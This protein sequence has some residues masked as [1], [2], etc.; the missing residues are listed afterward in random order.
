M[1]AAVACCVFAVRN[2][3]LK[4]S[5]I[6]RWMWTTLSTLWR[7]SCSKSTPAKLVCH[8]H[9]RLLYWLICAVINHC[10][11]LTTESWV[12]L[13][14]LTRCQTCTCLVLWTVSSCF[15][16]LIAISTGQCGEFSHRQLVNRNNFCIFVDRLALW[17]ITERLSAVRD[18]SLVWPVA[19]YITLRRWTAVWSRVQFG[20]CWHCTSKFWDRNTVIVRLLTARGQHC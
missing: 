15:C 16:T 6:I 4:L 19:I 1:S 2:R 18:Q 5:Q 20:K 9:Q 11:W 14:L 7:I 17:L 13:F 12:H 3:R 8:S 10:S